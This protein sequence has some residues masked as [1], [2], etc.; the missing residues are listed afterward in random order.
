MTADPLIAP[1][2]TAWEAH[3][4]VSSVTMCLPALEPWAGT[5]RSPAVAMAVAA[6]NIVAAGIKR[7]FIDEPLGFM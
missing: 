4:G 2:S 5:V 3:A 7:C 1:L 6:A